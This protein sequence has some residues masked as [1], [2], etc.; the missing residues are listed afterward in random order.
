MK[1]KFILFLTIFILF[2][3]L[4]SNIG[5][6][7][8]QNTPNF[9][10]P[11]CLI[12]NS[13]D[14]LFSNIKSQELYLKKPVLFNSNLIFLIEQLNVN[15][16]TAYIENLTAFGPRVTSTQACYDAGNYIFNEFKNMDL[17]VRY[18]NWS[19]GNLHGS[20]I[21]AT[22]YGMN[23]SSDEIYI[24]C[25]HYDSV[26]GCPGADDN[27]A[28]T[29]AVLAS[30]KIMSQ[31]R[32]NH[33][34]RFVCF[35]GEEQG[36]YGSKYYVQ[37]AV[38]NEDNIIVALNADMMG[39]AKT[40]E[41]ERKVKIFEDEYSEWVLDLT[42]DV[43]EQY[44]DYINL[45]VIPSGYTWGSD[46]YRFWEAGYNALFYFEYKWNP[47]YHLPSDIIENMNPMYATRV[48]K[49]I[50]ATLV[51]LSEGVSLNIAPTEPDINGPINGKI[52]EIYEYEIVSY[53]PNDDDLS[54]Y[55]EFEEGK[56]YWTSEK[57]PSG[58]SIRESWSWSLNILRPRS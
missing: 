42:V 50:M 40:E 46:H 41:D 56:G 48:S 7:N 24:I 49:L 30:A 3:Y 21:E 13:I 32:F 14:P 15:I 39:Y 47:N 37:E 25:G 54:Y 52:N 34:V 11:G 27:G 20:N 31:Y 58:E 29:A 33:T 19:N 4:L 51:V 36:L 43:S 38:S 55:I 35:S 45:L 1:N 5:L 16:V 53:D 6:A 23:D 26:P 28:G 8:N 10:A 12:G 2:S 9:P 17:D 57:Y 22:L 18:H 44:Y